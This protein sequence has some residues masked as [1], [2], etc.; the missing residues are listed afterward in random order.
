MK[1]S[2]KHTLPFDPKYMFVYVYTNTLKYMFDPKYMFAYIY[3]NTLTHI[4]IYKLKAHFHNMI[5]TLNI[6]KYSY[7][8]YSITLSQKYWL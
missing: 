5:P 1:Y 4:H 8:F 7:I 6:L 3:T 2:T